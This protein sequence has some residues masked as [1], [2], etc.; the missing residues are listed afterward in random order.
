MYFR[1]SYAKHD[2]QTL[3]QFFPKIYVRKMRNKRKIRGMSEAIAALILIAIAISVGIIVW[4]TITSTARNI[5]PKGSFLL[6]ES[7]D[8]SANTNVAT[9]RIKNIGQAPITIKSVYISGSSIT[10][11]TPNLPFTI[12]PGVETS[13]TV[14]F[15]SN[16]IQGTPY[17][18]TINYGVPNAPDGSVSYTFQVS[19]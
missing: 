12:N 18:L 11:A 1:T 8:A 5:A 15:S 14:T 2:I 6:I 17:V 3:K 16:F 7:V 19:Q 9:I 4:Y 10:G 13:F